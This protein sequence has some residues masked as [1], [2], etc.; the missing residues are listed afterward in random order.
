MAPRRQLG[1]RHDV[2]GLQVQPLRGV[3]RCDERDGYHG[4]RYCGL[5]EFD[6]YATYLGQA[7]LISLIENLDLG[8]RPASRLGERTVE[9]LWAIPWVFL[10]TPSRCIITG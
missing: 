1:Y 3:A 6:G 10:W 4:K 2:A 7:T 9:D 8:L 5:L